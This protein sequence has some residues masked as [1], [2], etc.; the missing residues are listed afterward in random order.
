MLQ[1]STAAREA[2]L[3]CLTNART[4]ASHGMSTYF[5]CEVIHAIMG[6]NEVGAVLKCHITC[7]IAKKRTFKLPMTKAR[8]RGTLN[9][10]DLYNL[11]HPA[12]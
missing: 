8:R 10:V 3:S 9:Q 7:R 12:S 1:C 11:L 5:P 2:A 6:I 4:A